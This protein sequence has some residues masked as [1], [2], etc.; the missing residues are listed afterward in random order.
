MVKNKLILLIAL[1]LSILFVAGCVDQTKPFFKE[2]ALANDYVPIGENTALN[3]KVSNPLEISF[4]GKVTFD[5]DKS[6][7]SITPQSKDVSVPN[8]DDMPFSVNVKILN[9]YKQDNPC[10]GTKDI[11][12]FLTDENG[13]N[14]DFKKVELNIINQ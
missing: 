7:I 9:S 2:T 14:L 8:T 4:N 12:L 6:C 5:Y 13:A 11:A 10:V 3:F 1:L